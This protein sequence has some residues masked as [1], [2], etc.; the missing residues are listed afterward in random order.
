MHGQIALRSETHFLLSPLPPYPA[1][2]LRTG[3]DQVLIVAD[4]HVGWEVSLAQE[5]IHVPSQTPKMKG[6]LLKLIELYNPTSLLFIG[7][8]KHTIAKAELEEWRDIPDLFETLS[9]K[10]SDIKV[11]LGNHDGSLEPLLPPSVKIFPSTGMTI[12]DAGFFHGN[13]WPAPKLLKC[14]S[15]VIGH[16]HPTVMFRD[17]L[18]LRITAQVWVKAQ[19]N[20]KRLAK[21]FL[22]GTGVRVKSNEDALKLLNQRFNVQFE[23]S[24]LFIMPHF[25]DFLG[26]RPIN[27]KSKESGGKSVEY[28]GP[29]LRS[30][31]V[32]IENAE[33]YL[34]DGTFLGTISQ[35]SVF[36]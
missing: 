23:A 11:V 6:K 26:G 14:H 12:G 3:K 24:E 32:D 5:G 28:L 10:V 1:L 19:L 2:L 22:K 21:A 30:G 20:K 7:D 9:K 18:G 8:V 15:L 35:L 25:N 4:L 36:G 29:I 17:P 33:I 34:L 31:C 27:R 13:A 16:V